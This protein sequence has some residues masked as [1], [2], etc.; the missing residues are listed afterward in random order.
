HLIGREDHDDV[1]LGRSLGHLF[2]R[3]ARIFGLG[4]RSTALLDADPHVHPAVAQVECMRVPLAAIT[5]NGE[6]FVL[7][8][9]EI[10]ICVI[11][12]IHGAFSL[13]DFPLSSTV[14]PLL[15]EADRTCVPRC[16]ATLPVRTLSLTP[17]G[18]SKL[19][20]A[21]IFSSSPVTSIT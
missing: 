1:G 14:S 21:L 11:I 15:E 9:R 5:N 16:I 20:K 3:E 4:P 19:R 7:E 8:Q 17:S 10:C 6:L 18:F 12:D 13:W 2:H